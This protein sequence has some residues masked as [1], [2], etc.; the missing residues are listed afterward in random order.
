MSNPP[1]SSSQP[2]SSENMPPP[3]S[4][5]PVLSYYND[6]ANRTPYVTRASMIIMVA[7][8]LASFF[9][10]AGMV[11]GNTPYFSIFSFEVYRLIL[12]PF[13]N[14]SIFNIV[15][16]ALFYPAMGTQMEVKMGSA[17]FLACIGTLTVATNVIFAAVCV[18]LY[19]FGMV[20]ALFF[21]CSGFWVVLFGLITIDCMQVR[22][23]SACV[24][25]G[26]VECA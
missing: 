13:V 20:E 10:Q 24:R 2:P 25:G 14:N 11:L 22:C 17:A 19:L 12:S 16:I 26:G 1:N 18:L 9:F 4:N 8:Y 6:W 23:V 3:P 5:N 7:T 15:L 21:D